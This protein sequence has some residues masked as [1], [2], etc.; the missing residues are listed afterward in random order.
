MTPAPHS[1]AFAVRH[2][3]NTITAVLRRSQALITVTLSTATAPIDTGTADGIRPE[4]GTPACDVCPHSLVGHDAISARFCS[5]TL[6]G[7]L[8]RG[9][10]CP[11]S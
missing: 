6:T 4:G 5:A 11:G 1:S 9:C 3:T 8:A 2:P 7:A 10:I